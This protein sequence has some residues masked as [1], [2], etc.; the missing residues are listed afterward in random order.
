MKDLSL[1]SL[2]GDE[3]IDIDCPTCNTEFQVEFS[4]VMEDGSSVVCPNC[5][6]EIVLNHDET[7][8]KTLK[9]SSDALKEFNKSMNDLEKT[10]KKF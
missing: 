5:K 1:E 4:A 6:Q 9:D 3:L 7:T 8:E 2:F 10:F